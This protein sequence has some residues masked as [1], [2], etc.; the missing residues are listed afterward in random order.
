MSLP[1]TSLV[2]GTPM[3]NDQLTTPFTN[4]DISDRMWGNCRESSRSDHLRIG[5]WN[6]GSLPLYNHHPKNNEIRQWIRQ[7]QFDIIGLSEINVHW[8]SIPAAHR[9]AERTVGWFESLHLSYTYMKY[10]PTNSPSQVG[11]TLIWSI[12]KAA[13][14]AEK[15]KESDTSGMGRWCSTTFNGKNGRRL[16][17]I[18]AYRC[19]SN[20][21][22]VL[23]VWS[24][25][26]LW[27]DQHRDDIDPRD[28]FTRDLVREIENWIANGDI[29][30]LGLDLNENIISADF[31]MQMTNLGLCEVLTHKHGTTPNTY[32]RGSVAIDGIYVSPLLANSLCGLLP[33]LGDH[34]PSWIDI[35]FH[36][37]FGTEPPI[38]QQR[39]RRLKLQDPRI[40]KKYV[41]SFAAYCSNTQLLPQLQRLQLRTDVET[42]DFSNEYD[43]LDN[44]RTKGMIQAEKSCRKLRMGAVDFCPEYHLLSQKVITW[45]LIVK[46]KRGGSVDS[47][48]F[49]RQLKKSALDRLQVHTLTFDQAI[50]QLRSAYIQLKLFSK[51]ADQ[52]RVSW[53]EELATARAVS[54]GLSAEQ[55]LKTMLHRERQRKEARIIKAVIRPKANLGLTMIQIPVDGSIKEVSSQQEMEQV[56]C[57]ELAARF[58]QAST[59]P[60]A[61]EPLLM[62]VGKLGTE[63]GAQQILNGTFECPPGTDYWTSRLIPF[64]K[65]SKSAKL[66][67]EAFTLHTTSSQHEEGW[68]KMKENISPGFSS[69]SF[70]QFKAAAA[71]PF[72]Q[73]IDSLLATIPYCTGIAP[74]RWKH[75]VDVM[76]QKQPGNFLVEKLRAILLFEADFNHNNKKFGRELMFHAEQSQD[77]AIEQFGSRKGMSAID[78]SLN[79]ALTFDIWRQERKPGAICS[80]DAKSCYDRILHNVASICLQRLGAPVEPII[81]MFKTIQELQHH[82]RTVYGNSVQTFSGAQWEV[83]IHGVG[84]GNGSG[85]QI[86]AA[87]SSPVFDMLRSVKCGSFF[88]S[89][90]TKVS[91]HFVGYA[92][93]DDTDLVASSWEHTS[94]EQVFENIQLALEAWQGGICATGGAIVPEKSHWYFVD[95]KWNNGIP[96]YKSVTETSR[97]LMVLDANGVSQQL[98]QLEPHMAERTLGVRLAPDGNM[99]TQSNFMRAQALQWCNSIAKGFFDQRLMYQALS[100]TIMKSLEYPLPA[101][102]LSSVQC[103]YIMKPIYKLCLPK[104]KVVGTFPISLRYS[105]IQHFGLQLPNLYWLQGYYHLDRL[106]RYAKSM[107]L[108]GQLIRHSL[109]NLRLELGCNGQLFDLPYNTLSRIATDTWLTHTWKFI[110]QYNLQLSLQVPDIPLQREFDSLLIPMFMA[111]GFQNEELQQLNRCRIFLKVTT[112]SDITCGFGEMITQEAW[113]GRC[114]DFRSTEHEWPK[115]GILPPSYW[116]LWQKALLTLCCRP[117]KLCNP[118]GNWLPTCS[119]QLRFDPGT[120]RVYQDVDGS[121]CFY[122]RQMSGVASRSNCGRFGNQQVCTRI[123]TTALPATAYRNR[124]FVHL[125]GY[126]AKT[127]V[128]RTHHPQSF[129]EFMRDSFP[130]P[131]SWITEAISFEGSLQRFEQLCRYQSVVLEAVSDG[132]FKDG[133]GTASWRINIQSEKEFFLGS[134]ITPGTTSD[135][136]AYRSEIAG[137]YGIAATVWCMK[138]FLDCNIQVEIGCDGLSAIRQCE[139][140][141]DSINPNLSHFDMIFAVRSLLHD[142]NGTIKWRHIKGHQD[143]HAELVLDK[144]ALY[145]V[146]MDTTA[147]Q[148]WSRTYRQDMLRPQHV[149]GEPAALFIPNH[150]LCTELKQ[151]LL[152]YL[153]SITSVPYWENHF[154]WPAGMGSTINWNSIGIAQGS[155]PLSRKIWLAKTVSG[156]FSHGKM[157]KR[158]KF[159]NNSTCPRCQEPLED[160]VHILRCSHPEAN[161]L[162]HQRVSELKRWMI[163][164]STSVL[165]ATTIC[166][167]LQSWYSSTDYNPLP[168]GL[169]IQFQTVFR[170]QDALGWHAFLGGFLTNQWESVQGMYLKSLLSKV[171]IRRWLSEL[172]RKLWLV[173][174]DLWDHRNT[175]LHDLEQGEVIRQLNLDIS[176]QFRLGCSSLPKD[177]KQLFTSENEVLGLPVP[178]RQLWLQRVIAARERYLSI[179]SGERQFMSRWINSTTQS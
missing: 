49:T 104:L 109:E 110:S 30:V 23:S 13:H 80:N 71:H 28:A 46:R 61:S 63:K 159:K 26:R 150:K 163:Q 122:S 101:T 92:F 10:W 27:L 37:I 34:R 139:R 171:T 130:A 69:L 21:T 89:A 53:I 173:S 133:H 124:S 54:S 125:T 166:E 121:I 7:Q 142:V 86:W 154:E 169:S 33:F 156:F 152:S 141:S 39:A 108:T 161:S 11:G 78:Q 36:L 105:A 40:V 41:D 35:P 62:A 134:V 3:G 100:T 66:V 50:A 112:L 73:Q 135:Q 158:W 60:F 24:Q 120:D 145:N 140:Y 143:D 82:I 165:V 153:G 70:A 68:K 114:N 22:G 178:N 132:S 176:E 6:C 79:K 90:I 147:K 45:R 170:L 128:P 77:I 168:V 137:L 16:R 48:Y 85:P 18:S 64:L 2:S 88:R 144:W 162:W 107:H 151:Q 177:T 29:I 113:N 172:L 14:R 75:G 20:K 51:T 96:I 106:I 175:L 76:L 25:Q 12:N 5:F 59:T 9:L 157:M 15:A 149:F 138:K 174:W 97:Q 67:K 167:R 129:L 146:Q 93:V 111:K 103:D 56:L 72:L 98:R 8:K 119:V 123:P 4:M 126:A 74:N 17:V 155:L 179:Y 148:Y 83:P 99:K 58:H 43:R 116:T 131:F 31:T 32:I 117:R 115:Q 38:I 1:V 57:S 84:Q 102:T 136:S 164:N 52:K 127:S 160:A 19:V 65:Y 91:I 42:E 55:E 47:R 81:S 95:F 87:V 118:L 44:I 94:A